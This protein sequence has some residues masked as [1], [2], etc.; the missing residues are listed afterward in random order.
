MRL[1]NTLALL[2]AAVLALGAFASTGTAAP[3]TIINQTYS[4]TFPA[5]ISGTL[6]TQ[7]TVLEEAF[8]LTS[9]STV[10]AYTTSYAMGG[11]EPSLI[12]YGPDGT[13][14]GGSMTG[15]PGATG[16]PAL[17]VVLSQAGLAAGT[18]TLAVM[19][20]NVSQDLTATGLSDGFASNSGN[21]TTFVDSNGNTRTGNYS[22][23]LSLASASTGGGPGTATPEPS[24]A[25]LTLL[26]A[27]AMGVV[28]G[29]KHLSVTAK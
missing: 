27:L 8:T 20:Y 2:P 1:K 26:P 17:D 13:S 21:G 14:A 19:D 15:G 7:N 16:N 29:R 12:L 3:A 9:T 28:Y 18:Y 22:V 25:L 24:T 5:T 4:G 11:F 23:N 6:P 10:T